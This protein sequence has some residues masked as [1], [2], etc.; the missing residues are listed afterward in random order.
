MQDENPI[1]SIHSALILATTEETFYTVS[2]STDGTYYFAIFATNIHGNS[3][4]SN[5]IEVNVDVLVNAPPSISKPPDC[6]FYTD[7]PTALISWIIEDD[8]IGNATYILFVN[9]TAIY[10]GNWTNG[11]EII[12]NCSAMTV[13]WYLISIEA[14]DGFGE[15]ISDEVLVHMILR[16]D[17]ATTDTVTTSPAETTET[18]E[19]TEPTHTTSTN[20]TNGNGAGGP[21]LGIGGI[22]AIS[23]GSVGVAGSVVFLFIRRKRL[24][25]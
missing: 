1:I 6:S 8:T 4:V 9:N 18:T 11:D 19:A 17:S 23:G 13:G 21:G 22:I 25:K 14:H 12:V 15:M 3:T 2:L 7:D 16:E 20:T 10:T 5:S 24:K